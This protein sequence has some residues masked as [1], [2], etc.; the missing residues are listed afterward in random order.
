MAQVRHMSVTAVA[1]SS[2]KYVGFVCLF[3]SEDGIEGV[4]MMCHILTCQHI[5]VHTLLHLYK[6]KRVKYSV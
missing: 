1:A 5:N 4:F 3:Y 2:I 6:V